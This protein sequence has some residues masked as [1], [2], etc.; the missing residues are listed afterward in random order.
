MPLT[1]GVRVAQERL[2]AGPVGRAGEVERDFGI[3][4]A[5]RAGERD[6]PRRVVDDELDGHAQ[7][8]PVRLGHRNGTEWMGVGVARAAGHEEGDGAGIVGLE[9]VLG[10]A[11]CP[12]RLRL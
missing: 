2:V 6:R 3:R 12:R 8:F 9:P 11:G 5:D 4:R 1:S 10:V 7:F